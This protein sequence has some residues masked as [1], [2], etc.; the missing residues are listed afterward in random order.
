MNNQFSENLKKIRK[1]HNLS[2]EEL[3]DELGVSRQAISK[4][5][6]SQA[7]PEMDKIIMLCDKFNLNIDDLLH[8]DIKEVKGEEESK[9]KLNNSIYSFLKG[10]TDTINMFSRMTFKS[11]IKCIFEQILIAFI[12]FIVSVILVGAVG[13][14][15]SN[16]TALL[17]GRIES[18]INRIFEGLLILGCVVASIVIM[19]HVF[20]SRYLNYYEEVKDVETSKDDNCSTDDNKI[21]LDK[22]DNKIIIRDPKHSEYRFLSGLY[23]VFIIIIKFFLS[24]VALFTIFAVVCLLI[25]LVLSFL[26]IKTGIFFVG[27]LL[28]IISL[29]II[30]V[31]ILLALINFIFNRKSNKKIMIYSFILSILVFGVG[32]GLSFLG[33]LSFDVVENDESML[34]TQTLE[35]NMTPDT[36]INTHYYDVE[37]VESDINNIRVEYKLNKYCD[38]E[39]AVEEDNS[40]AGYAICKNEMKI[41]REIVKNIGEKKI[42]SMSTNIVGV[43]IYANKANIE[44]L[45]NNNIK[46]QQEI[47]SRNNYTNE[48]EIEIE[49]IKNE[50]DELRNKVNNIKTE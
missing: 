2:Q 28:A 31:I 25:G 17:P 34:K 13:L 50:N 29:S 15:I 24:L 47:E 9:K 26:T 23:K 16:F 45:K 14:L 5:E 27:L 30:G 40:I 46:K 42:T 48:L 4:W 21:K 41:V 38:V 43:K 11:K 12:L 33:S 49:K 10:I 18:F 36:I 8:K 3:A 22:K 1:E 20:K 19:A 44:I 35:Y 7:Y 32:L 39:E 6:S 37:Y